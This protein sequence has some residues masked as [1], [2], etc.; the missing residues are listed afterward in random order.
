MSTMN[1]TNMSVKRPTTKVIHAP[2]GASSISI[3]GEGEEVQRP[4]AG[5]KGAKPAFKASFEPSFEC[6]APAAVPEPVVVVEKA[7]EP[8]PE[9]VVAAAP[10]VSKTPATTTEDVAVQAAQPVPATPSVAVLFSGCSPVNA[11]LQARTLE[12]LGA[13]GV[14]ATAT[15]AD[16]L[17]LPCTAK[18]MLA[19]GK[20]TAVIVAGAFAEDKAFDKEMA[21]ALA[22]G[23]VQ[24]SVEQAGA[25]V[26]VPGLF[27]AATEAEAMAKVAE[28]PVASWV[29]L[30]VPSLA[31]VAV[32]PV[33]ETASVAAPAVVVAT[34]EKKT[35]S[36]PSVTEKMAEVSLN[37]TAPVDTPTRRNRG[38]G[39][40]SIIFG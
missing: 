3:F 18:Q 8:E 16:L 25:A 26:V 20:Y 12:V 28:A 35:G 34:P 30:A 27:F 23:L 38:A 33:V 5:G 21:G 37:K 39:P 19:T 4:A 40:S 13:R 7:P 1:S 9:V 32:E 36:T 24:L 17:Q 22:T 11:L 29:N 2:G 10:A 6:S 14:T 15:M 31:T